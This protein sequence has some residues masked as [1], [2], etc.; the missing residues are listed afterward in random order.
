M[1]SQA[2]KPHNCSAR[3]PASPRAPPTVARV[4]Q[5][6]GLVYVILGSH[7]NRGWPLALGQISSP[8]SPGRT[9]QTKSG[10]LSPPLST[11]EDST[12]EFGVPSGKM[13]RV[14]K[15]SPGHLFGGC[16]AVGSR[17]NSSTPGNREGLGYQSHGAS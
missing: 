5:P 15:V 1:A 11:S 7:G 6:R 10:Q 4:T 3:D 8:S 12:Q 9:P 13:T 2:H 17:C 14:I 16:T